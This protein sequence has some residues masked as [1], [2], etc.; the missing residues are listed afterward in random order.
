M[1]R[2]LTRIIEYVLPLKSAC[3]HVSQPG[4]YCSRRIVRVPVL[5]DNA[6]A[7]S[8]VENKELTY[9]EQSLQPR[10][11]CVLTSCAT[12]TFRCPSMF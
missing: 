12:V 1:D 8:C 10:S 4:R 5:R 2:R 11:G 3:R 9:E 6:P 7:R